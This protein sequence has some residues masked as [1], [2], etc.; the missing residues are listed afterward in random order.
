ML[1]PA[2]LLTP[3]VTLGK[4][5]WDESGDRAGG[6]GAKR[7]QLPKRSVLKKDYREQGEHSHYFSVCCNK[8]SLGCCKLLYLALWIG[9]AVFK[10][11]MSYTPLPLSLVSSLQNTAP[12]VCLLPSGLG[13]TQHCITG[14]KVSLSLLVSLATFAFPILL[15]PVDSLVQEAF[16]IPVCKTPRASR[17]C[18]KSIIRIWGLR[19][20]RGKV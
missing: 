20:G 14:S 6:G 17:M 15:V 5:L 7:S 13:S 3:R 8:L 4:S 16:S 11:N 2:L 12:S 1:I 19:W 9:C 10:R 18:P